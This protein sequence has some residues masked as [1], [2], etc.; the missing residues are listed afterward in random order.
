VGNAFYYQTG[1]G[2]Q[3]GTH[4]AGVCHEGRQMQTVVD[5]TA[6]YYW[7]QDASMRFTH[8]HLSSARAL[9]HRPEDYLGCSFWELDGME[10]TLAPVWQHFRQLCAKG[11]PIERLLISHR[12]LNSSL[13]FSRID[14]VPLFDKYGEVSG[15]QGVVREVT[16]AKR[17]EDY[18]STFD[19]AAIGIGHVSMSGKFIHVNRK[20]CDM[21]GYSAEELIGRSVK[22]ISH[23]DDVNIADELHERLR[24]GE[25]KSFKA[26]KRY[27]R[28]D[29][30]VL[31][32]GLTSAIKLD[33]YG[34]G[35]YDISMVEDISARKQAEDQ[36]HYL[37]THD[38]LT[39][40]PN[41]TLFNQLLTYSLASSKRYKRQFALVFIA[42]DRFKHVNDSLGSDAG[43]KLL[44]EM[45]DRLKQTVRS[46][47]VVARLGG[48]EFVV[49]LEETGGQENVENVCR[50]LLQVVSMPMVI[51]GRECSLTASLGVSLFPQDGVEEK[52]LLKN[53][54]MALNAAKEEGKNNVQFYNATRR[55][56]TVENLAMEMA[57]RHAIELEELSLQYQ[58]K[59]QV[60]T[61]R[62]CGVEAL[63][64]WNNP[65]FGQVS[66]VDFI[67]L[68]EDSGLIIPIGRW[69]LREAMQQLQRWQLAGLPTISM[70]VNLSPR[71]F[72]DP[73]LLP[74]ICRL[75]EE[76]QL[77]PKLLE[78]EVTESTV[79]HDA[80]KAMDVLMAI[81]ALGIHIAIDDFGTGY[82]SLSKL[83]TFP[84]NTLKIDRSF[85]RDIVND[86]EDRI[87]TQTIIKMGQT[88]G[89]AV[90]AEGVETNEQLALLK[91][92]GCDVI[93]GYLYSKP[94]TP[95]K[96]S[97]YLG[98]Y[99]GCDKY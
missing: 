19:L 61:G 82:S 65:D 91:A 20:L 9:S 81:S 48:D 41:R 58:P 2:M 93:Q 18:A 75:L 40:L 44:R 98:Q 97:Q 84:V 88:L 68:A 34:N 36:V 94:L 43:D 8:V 77:D 13:R 69:V 70:A 25:I 95:D 33:D 30:S 46:S 56:V 10:T 92:N 74:E 86:E 62:V 28:K 11:A 85:I 96:L 17:N 72:R 63:L 26:E 78:I 21:L 14:G 37:A 52:S 12:E 80:S 42:M 60:T 83:K 99:G 76:M 50:N 7:E 39:G 35:M 32:V 38:S 31:W 5:L 15:Y 89:L 87:L 57:L 45:G 64:R 29:K 73:D 16:E 22:S 27:I 67:P 23:P 4:A 90:V 79:M 51:S 1:T 59:V 47:D 55:N 71:Q 66:P 49:L 54:D 24:C 6:E 53:A 3:P